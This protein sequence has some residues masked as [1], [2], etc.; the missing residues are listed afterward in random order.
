[1]FQGSQNHYL[2]MAIGGVGQDGQPAQGLVAVAFKK[3]HE[4]AT[5]QGKTL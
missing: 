4:N 5:V 1:M 3:Y 2:S